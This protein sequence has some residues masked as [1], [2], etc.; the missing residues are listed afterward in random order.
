MS[1]D[2][3][4]CLWAYNTC[5]YTGCSC[6][7]TTE[8]YVFVDTQHLSLDTYFIVIFDEINTVLWVKHEIAN[9]DTL[10]TSS[11]YCFDI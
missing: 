10:T 3:Q 6:G 5:L 7:Y 2:T 1:L 4:L 9:S 8:T 11:S